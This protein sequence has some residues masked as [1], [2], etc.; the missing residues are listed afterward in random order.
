MEYAKFMAVFVLFMFLA[1]TLVIATHTT[2]A[3]SGVQYGLKQL[4]ETIKG[5]FGALIAVL[6]VL[7]AIA[8]AAGNMLG[9]DAGARAKVWGQNLLI[10]AG[11]SLVVYVVAPM[12]LNAISPDVDATI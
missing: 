9:S 10:G 7:A 5:F 1:S 3:Q 4:K 12:V 8:Y 11:I 6:I 2:T